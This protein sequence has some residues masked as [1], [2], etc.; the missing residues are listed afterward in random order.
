MLHTKPREAHPECKARRN[1]S[2]IE[3]HLK[4]ATINIDQRTFLGLPSKLLQTSAG[5]PTPATRAKSNC[6]GRDF[7]HAISF[8]IFTPSRIC[9]E[10]ST[11]Q[12]SASRMPMRKLHS[13]NT[14]KY[15]GF[16]GNRTLHRSEHDMPWPSPGATRYIPPV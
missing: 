3:L 1:I 15:N 5:R 16:R 14:S 6:R 4:S 12:T 7:C 13:L 11:Y 9:H 10:H 8:H 2:Y